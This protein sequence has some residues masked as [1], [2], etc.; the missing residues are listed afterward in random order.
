ML[1]C[2]VTCHRQDET[3][4]QMPV[5]KLKNTNG[6]AITSAG[7]DFAYI[8]QF[9]YEYGRSQP[10]FPLWPFPDPECI[11]LIFRKPEQGGHLMEADTQSPVGKITLHLYVQKRH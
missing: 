11:L 3:H 1:S 4:K 9:P 8:Y 2:F 10:C 7:T 6:R 5:N